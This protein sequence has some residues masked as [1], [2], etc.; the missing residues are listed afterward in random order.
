MSDIK[1]TEDNEIDL[2]SGGVELTTGIEAI[3]QHLKNRLSLIKGEYFRDRGVGV[4]Y[5]ERVFIKNADLAVIRSMF[6]QIILGTPGVDQLD[7]LQL[8]YE[9]R[10]LTLKAEGRSLDQGPF[11]LTLPLVI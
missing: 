9:D 5:F 8:S 3:R 6:R 2:T 11:T 7:D 4:P 10:V 1:L